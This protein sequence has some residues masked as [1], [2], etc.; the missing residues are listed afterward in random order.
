MV[1][2]STG[3]DG[4]SARGKCG[5]NGQKGGFLCQKGALGWFLG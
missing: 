3:F 1:S 2:A 5:E 4:S